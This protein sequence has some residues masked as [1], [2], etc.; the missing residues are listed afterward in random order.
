MELTNTKSG[1]TIESTLTENEVIEGLRKLRGGFAASLVQNRNRLTANQ[2]FWAHK[3]VND[4]NRPRPTF[5]T[6]CS[7]IVKM[8]TDALVNLK[9]PKIFFE[10]HE[11]RPMVR[12]T[13]SINGQYP[14]SVT[15]A[16]GGYGTDYYGRNRQKTEHS[17]QTHKC[18]DEIK[19]LVREFAADPVAT[20]AKYGETS[21]FVLLLPS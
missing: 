19:A 3:L 7:P 15:L 8:L 16:N 17:H 20:V 6:N 10:E 13:L 2:L 14:G 1:E 4:A 21:G 18:T 5:D 9:F 12:F 11:G